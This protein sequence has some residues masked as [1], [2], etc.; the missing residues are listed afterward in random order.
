MEVDQLQGNFQIQFFCVCVC[1]CVSVRFYALCTPIPLLFHFAEQKVSAAS[2]RWHRCKTQ[3]IWE[4]SE[5]VGV[6]RSSGAALR[7]RNAA[8]PNTGS[9]FKHSCQQTDTKLKC[10]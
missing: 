6:V 8:P 5:A 9:S 1:V 3:L 4:R 10:P 7:G 2:T